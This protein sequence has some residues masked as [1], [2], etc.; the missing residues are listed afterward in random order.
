MIRVQPPIGAR[1]GPAGTGRGVP[2]SAK[3][4]WRMLVGGTMDDR[5]QRTGKLSPVA[6]AMR[7]APRLLREKSGAVA[8][9]SVLMLPILIGFAGLAVDVGF[10]YMQFR[11]LKA[12]ADSAAVTAAME[13]TN[14]SA[15]TAEAQ[16]KADAVRNGIGSTQVT[17]NM[18]PASPSSF[19]GDS[20]AA[21]VVI[22]DTLPLFFTSLFGV[23]APVVTVRAVAT[24]VFGTE[25]QT[26][27]IVSLADTADAIK[28]DSNATITATGCAIQVDSTSGTGLNNL[29]TPTDPDTSA[30]VPAVTAD[31]ICIT[32]NSFGSATGDSGFST[33]PLTGAGN[34]PALGDPLAGRDQALLPDPNSCDF[35]GLTIDNGTVTAGGTRTASSVVA[36][37][38]SAA[39]DSSIHSCNSAHCDCAGSGFSVITLQPGVYCGGIQM[40]ACA[41]V[42][43]EAGNYTI[44]DGQ[45]WTDGNANMVGDGVGFFLSGAAPATSTATI[46]FDANSRVVLT[47]PSSPD[48]AVDPMSGLIFFEDRNAR[49]TPELIHEVDSNGE[50]YFEGSLY[51][52]KGTVHI[53]SNGVASANSPYT[54]IIARKLNIDSNAKLTLNNSV[55]GASGVTGSGPPAC[56]NVPGVSGSSIEVPCC[57]RAALAE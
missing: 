44:S 25:P 33:T 23:T 40:N 17:V 15:G 27:C 39:Y 30:A 22:T 24:Q 37:P 12:V 55:C 21:E 36:E 45:L 8:I 1:C 18:P 29:A 54:Q 51:F 16:A 3:P 38:S 19:S 14:G 48:P 13:I 52:P 6:A 7:S 43:F 26:A 42:V 47:A 53:D 28:L 5:K 2:L 31:N 34:C 41:N 56:T 4:A 50:I 11:K 46:N 35:N 49:T 10:W 32:G 9:M 57:P 20:N